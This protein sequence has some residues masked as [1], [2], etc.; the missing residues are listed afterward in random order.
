MNW[1]C[2]AFAFTLPGLLCTGLGRGRQPGV[3]SLLG[4]LAVGIAGLLFLLG[5]HAP[6]LHRTAEWLPLLPDGAF[7]LRLDGLAAVMLCVV[8]FV[9]TCIYVYSLSYMGSD[10][11]R[12]RFFC[13]LD[14]FVATMTLLVLAGNLAV[15][16]AGWAGV[17]LSSFL[18]IAF[19]RDKPGTLGAGLQALA[20][21]AIGDAALLLACVLVPKGAG[22]LATLAQIEP[23]R[24]PGGMTTLGWL[25]VVAASAK[26]AQG[27]LYFWLPSAMAGPTPVSALIHA[28]TMV[29]AGVYLLVRTDAVLELAPSVLH[30]VVW[31]GV[32]TALLSSFASLSQT[33]YKRG[34]AYSTCSQLGY[35]FAAVGL[36]APFAAMFHLVTHAS[37]KAL[38]FLCAGA[39]IHAAHGEEDLH[40][41]RGMRRQLPQVM[42]LTLVGSLA[43]CGLPVLTAGAFSKDLIL[44]AG[45]HHDAGLGWLLV[46]AVFFTGLYCGRLF[47]GVFGAAAPPADAAPVHRP[48]ALL[49]LPL[50]PLALGALALGWLGTPLAALLA[51]LLPNGGTPDGEP[52][53]MHLISNLGL[54]AGGLGLAGFLAAGAWQK[55]TAGAARLPSFG[56]DWV[57]GAARL[58]GGIAAGVAGLHN[59]RLG[60]Y[61]FT[62]LIGIAVILFFALGRTL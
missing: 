25:L 33:N 29:A 14:L 40:R 61:L 34:L 32:V 15:L 7:A 45:L 28:A 42:G 62:S 57:P 1:L 50:L 11:G 13:C 10:P 21:N 41:L 56:L 6:V 9:S 37:F 48:D 44:E 60:F 38:L 16:V 23:A 46:G 52:F 59:G 12:R 54:V 8:G 58:C 55:A 51:P 22:D 35:M 2:W 27:L 19:W 30:G 53:A 39:V 18:L 47:F 20:A 4:P 31:I 26:S 24:L 3:A 36:H 5:D 17:G 49:I 43:L